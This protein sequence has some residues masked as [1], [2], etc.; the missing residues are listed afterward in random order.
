VAERQA[1]AQSALI[2]VEK[3]VLY[4][5]FS[6][7]GSIGLEADDFNTLW[8]RS[9]SWTGLINPGFSWPILNYG[10]IKN[11]IRAQDAAFQAAALNYQNTVL[12]AAQEVESSLAGFRGSREQAAQLALS[13]AAAKDAADLSSQQYVEGAADYTRVLQALQTLLEVE[14]RH[15]TVRGDVAANLISTYKA[16][17][18]GWEIRKGLSEMVS[19]AVREEMRQRTDWGNYFKRLDE[20]IGRPDEPTFYKRFDPAGNEEKR[21]LPVREQ[22]P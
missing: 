5:S 3:A 12:T 11:N 18:G 1:A 2:G 15:T 8:N 21:T 14:S 9:K 4:P 13:M 10:R 7:V 22:Q 16:L 19:P 20:T 6:L 17:G